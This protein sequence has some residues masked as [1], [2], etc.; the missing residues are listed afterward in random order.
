MTTEKTC[1]KCTAALPAAP[2]PGRPRRYCSSACRRT[3]AYELRRVQ[4]GLVKVEGQLVGARAG[5]WGPDA[6]KV[7]SVFEAER[8]R[9]EERLLVLLEGTT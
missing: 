6:T 5:W 3:A 8:V 4:A 2:G 7:V 1:R 9:L